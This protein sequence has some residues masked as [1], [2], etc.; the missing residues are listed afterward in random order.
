MPRLNSEKGR[1]VHHQLTSA[2]FEIM[3]DDFNVAQAWM[4]EQLKSRVCL[5]R[6]ETSNSLKTDREL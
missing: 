4:V 2:E 3:M 1:V 5:E 6:A